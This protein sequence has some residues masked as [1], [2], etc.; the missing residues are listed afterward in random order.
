MACSLRSRIRLHQKAGAHGV[1]R[2]VNICRRSSEAWNRR[3]KPVVAASPSLRYVDISARRG[4]QRCRSAS[5]ALWQ[6]WMDP[7]GCNPGHACSERL[8]HTRARIGADDDDDDGDDIISMWESGSCLMA[9]AGAWPHPG[10]P[11]CLCGHRPIGGG[12]RC[13]ATPWVR[14]RTSVQYCNITAVSQQGKA[15]VRNGRITPCCA[16]HAWHVAMAVVP[17][18]MLITFVAVVVT[19]WPWV[20]QSRSTSIYQ[21]H[22]IWHCTLARRGEPASPVVGGWRLQH[23]RRHGSELPAPPAPVP[24]ASMPAIS[25]RLPRAGLQGSVPDCNSAASPPLRTP[26]SPA[27]VHYCI[28]L[29]RA[30]LRPPSFTLRFASAAPRTTR[31]RR[32]QLSGRDVPHGP[33]FAGASA[34]FVTVEHASASNM[35]DGQW[36][37]TAGVARVKQETLRSSC[38][39]LR[40]RPCCCDGPPEGQAGAPACQPISAR[41]CCPVHAAHVHERIP[42]VCILQRV[43][44]VTPPSGRQPMMPATPRPCRPLCPTSQAGDRIGQPAVG[45]ASVG[46][47]S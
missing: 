36:E 22:Q 16:P 37:C 3:S 15:G 28:Y 20:L 7:H 18:S 8:K 6:Q 10:L 4:R 24:L 39:Q 19:P 42:G 26:P 17:K 21:A 5:A 23:Q 14:S 40:C 29:P 34:V 27:G 45:C 35:S 32:Q 13:P 46:C 12:W 41:W 2:V 25:G 43:H 38:P 47:A 31:R 44:G 9:A 1:D 11:R 33:G 30:R